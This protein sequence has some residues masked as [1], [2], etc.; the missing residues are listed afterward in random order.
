MKPLPTIS[1]AHHRRKSHYVDE[2]LQKFLLVGLVVLEAGLAGMLAWMMFWRLNQIIEENLY[3]VHL[4]DAGPI[5]I[6][7]MQEALILLGIFSA[8]NLIALVLVDFIW[9]R[10]VYSILRL[11]MQLMGKTS[12]LDFTSD[13]E[14]RHQHQILE[15][16]ETQREQDRN[17]LIEIR[18]QLSRINPVTTTNDVQDV[19]DVLESLDELLPKAS[20]TLK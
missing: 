16:A 4:A 14:I 17:R 5:L 1:Q 13:P 3:R 9:R 12:R 10:Y 11:F 6:P 19:S 2:T 20:A 15:L 8:V 7:L 18:T